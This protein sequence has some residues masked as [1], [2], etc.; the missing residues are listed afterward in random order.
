M[1]RTYHVV[2]SHEPST[3]KY[4]EEN[5][6]PESTYETLNGL[7]G[8]QFDQRSPSKR[9]AEDVSK[10][11]IGDHQECRDPEPYKAFQDIIDNEV[12]REDYCQ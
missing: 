11:V 9:D 1:H 4:A 3:P 5:S 12:A 7:L 6:A 8:R 10:D 2:E